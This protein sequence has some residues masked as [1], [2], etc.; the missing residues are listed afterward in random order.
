[1]SGSETQLQVNNF[2]KGILWG[3]SVD[4]VTR[5]GNSQPAFKIQ[6]KFPSPNLTCIIRS[7]SKFLSRIRT[8]TGT[9]YYKKKYIKMQLVVIQFL[10]DRKLS[11]K[12]PPSHTISKFCYKD[13][14]FNFTDL[15]R[16]FKV[17]P[18]IF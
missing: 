11:T 18:A 6:K 4:K 8:N 12:A 9:I 16:C 2:V 14:V 3:T 5:T 1:M 13:Q 7:R 10:K 17:W 15:N